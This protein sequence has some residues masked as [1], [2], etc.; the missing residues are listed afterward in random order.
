M[1][2]QQRL[3]LEV[4]WEALEDAGVNERSLAGSDTGVF[5]GAIW[6]D[7]ADLASGNTGGL[8]SHSATGRALN[9]IANR[10]SYVLGLRGPSVVLDSACSSSLLAVHL[11]CQSIQSGESSMA[12]A[13]GVNL[14]LSPETMVSLS[15]F[16]GLSPDGRC[17]AFDARA[18]GFG[19]G[20]GCGVVVLKP[21]SRALADG[22]HIWCTIRG[23]AANNDGL[24]N[25][26]TAPNPAAQEGVLRA[27]YR[28]AGIAPIRCTTSKRT[29]PEPRSATPSRPW[30]SVP[31]WERTDLKTGPCASDRSKPTWDTSKRRRESPA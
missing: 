20:E 16:G 24:S 17:K 18:D 23:S 1:D 6:H 31:C 26:L 10:L 22:D 15:R 14:L 2:P 4:A 7:Y 21:L 11:A 29:A 3:F 8:S 28:N 30:P 9:M 13:G 19:R 25:G 5:A 12:I 27:A